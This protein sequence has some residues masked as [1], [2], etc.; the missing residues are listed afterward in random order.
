MVLS[1]WVEQDS[2]LGTIGYNFENHLTVERA[3]PVI[4]GLKPIKGREW[5]FQVP[6]EPGVSS[7]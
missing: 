4:Y 7:F 5:G 3:D 6:G 2:E 1:F